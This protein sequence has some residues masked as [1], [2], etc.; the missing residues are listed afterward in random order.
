MTDRITVL[1]NG[2]LVSTVQTSEVDL[3]GLVALMTDNWQSRKRLTERRV[4][5][6]VL[7]VNRLASVDQKVKDASFVVREGRSWGFSAWAAVAER[8]C[9]RPFMDCGRVLGVKSF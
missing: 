2:E 7:R 1:K 9:W 6:E 8:S 3:D 4:G 5:A